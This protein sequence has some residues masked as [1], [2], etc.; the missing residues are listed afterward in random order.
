MSWSREKAPVLMSSWSSAA[1]A[2]ALRV[3]RA[4]V[5]FLWYRCWV[6]VRVICGSV[7]VR[8]V[9]F[10]VRHDHPSGAFVRVSL[11]RILQPFN[12]INLTQ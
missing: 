11:G 9:V 5:A 12:T 4:M 1:A 10:Y 3:R 8:K 2:L 6:V 7:E